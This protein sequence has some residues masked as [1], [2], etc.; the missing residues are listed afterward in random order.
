[1][2]TREFTRPRMPVRALALLTAGGIAV[3]AVLAA[4]VPLVVGGALVAGG[5]NV[6][7]D[8]RPVGIQ[9][10]DEAIEHRVDNVVY[11]RFPIEPVNL[12]VTSYNRKVLL[13]GQ[14]HDEKTRAEIESLVARVENVAQVVNE[15]QIAPVSSTG[16]RADDTLLASK[17]RGALLGLREP[18]FTVIKTRI[19]AS[20]VYLMGRVTNSEGE[21]AAK[22]ASRVEGAKGVVK[23]FE[24][25]APAEL[26]KP[27]QPAPI[28]EGGA[29]KP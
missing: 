10:E 20:V 5:A 29:R 1:M 6:A 12:Y 23:V 16:Q 17:V 27:P 2:N 24:Y 28:S 15:L 25:I 19:T 21:G 18:P 14:V 7:S 11:T 13:T 9:L 4:C 3:G 8:R 22:A 26:E